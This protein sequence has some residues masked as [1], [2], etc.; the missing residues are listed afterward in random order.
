MEVSTDYLLL[1][2]G[3]LYVEKEL[4]LAQGI[5][6]Q[7]RINELEAE[8]SVPGPALPEEEDDEAAQ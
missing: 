3:R 8:A 4:V 2:I 5:G 7:A 6:L 1:V